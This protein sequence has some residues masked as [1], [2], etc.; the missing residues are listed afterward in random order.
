MK[1]LKLLKNAVTGHAMAPNISKAFL[2]VCSALAAALLAFPPVA[3]TAPK[4]T[5]TDTIGSGG[6][7]AY[8]NSNFNY[9]PSMPG[10]GNTIVIFDPGPEPS[11]N[12]LTFN[13]DEIQGMSVVGGGSQNG[14]SVDNV[15]IITSNAGDATSATNYAKFAVGGVAAG[16]NYTQ[17]VTVTGNDILVDSSA[18]DYVVVEQIIGGLANPYPGQTD[19]YATLVE[20]N[21][22]TFKTGSVMK[23]G[24]VTKLIFGAVVSGNLAYDVFGEASTNTVT[25]EGGSVAQAYSIVGGKVD[26]ATSSATNARMLVHDNKVVIEGDDDIGTVAVGGS[27]YGG[28]AGTGTGSDEDEEDEDDRYY[29]IH[30]YDNEVSISRGTVTNSVVG[31]HGLEV[32]NGIFKNNTV[33]ISG[34]AQVTGWVSGGR[35]AIGSSNNTVEANKSYIKGGSVGGNAYGGRVITGTALSNF[36]AVTGGT[37]GGDA[38]GGYVEQGDGEVTTNYVTVNTADAASSI[39]G[40]YGARSSDGVATGNHAD[41]TV[42]NNHALTLTGNV[43]GAWVAGAGGAAASGNYVDINIGQGTFAATTGNGLVVGALID[44]NGNSTDNRVSIAFTNAAGIMN[45]DGNVTGADVGGNGAISYNQGVKAVN[46]NVGSGTLNLGNTF[47]SGNIIGAQLGGDGNITGSAVLISVGSGS[48]SYAEDLFGASLVGS[49]N[50]ASN[51]VDIEINNNGTFNG[52]GDMSAANVYTDGT[53]SS[54]TVNVRL[55]TGATVDLGTAVTGAKVIGTGNATSNKVTISCLSSAACA[56]A[57]ADTV[58]GGTAATGT[59]SLNEVHLLGAA[60]VSGEVTG[61]HSGNGAA[62]NN[63]VWLSGNTAVTGGVN[64]AYGWTSATGNHVYVNDLVGGVDGEIRGGYS[65]ASSGDAS[66]N[67]V[68]ISDSKIKNSVYGGSVYYPSLGT[69]QN[70]TVTLSGTIDL[71]GISSSAKLAGGNV[72]TTG[73]DGFTGNKLVL[74]NVTP[75]SSIDRFD[76]V[77]NFQTYDIKIDSA[78]ARAATS[79]AAPLLL[80]NNATFGDGASGKSDIAIVIEGADRLSVGETLYMASNSINS[81]GIG[82]VTVTQ[83]LTVYTVSPSAAGFTIDWLST[84]DEARALSELPLADVSFVNRGSD[85]IASQAIPAAIESVAGQVG[86]VAFAAVG[87]GWHRTETGSHIDVK[88]VSAD[89]GVAVG[90]ETSFGAFAAGAFFEFGD[91]TFE[92]FN[93]IGGIVGFHGEGDVSYW[94]GG[95]FARLDFGQKDASRPYFEASFRAG[96]TNAEFR[97]RDF[98][99]ASGAEI[100]Y[101]MDAKYW[102]FHAGGGY[103]I[104]FSSI[105]ATLD[106]SA[107]YFHT[108]RDGDDV[109]VD[110]DRTNLSA[111]TSSRIIAGGRLTGQLTRSLK[112]YVGLYYEHEF[113]GDSVVTYVGSP[114]PKAS[115]GGSTGIGELGLIVS[116]PDSPVEVQ[117][118][119][120]GSAGRRDSF[121]G[122]LSINYTF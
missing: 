9:M 21:T 44:A 116:T 3:F 32:N 88:G 71:S 122:S 58:I 92:S 37:I 14:E 62:L 13:S 16:A 104:E 25:F 33:E 109:L 67:F 48:L 56:Q 64:G 83:H 95:V 75:T 5:D 47:G 36:V 117:M 102:G 99:F 82:T 73:A 26:G 11:G 106:L 65:R 53:A 38:Y 100:K 89:V 85:L 50:A 45:F 42:A 51:S 121:S 69:T 120:Q 6:W 7:I 61:G 114:L 101:D 35:D 87:Y 79:S 54:N 2:A 57:A 8:P 29:V 81:A 78:R 107:T 66:H 40:A 22:V 17:D 1:N 70:N 74:D 115:L 31:G 84:G 110:G 68:D 55:G 4:Q 91:G 96:K 63:S 20:A 111:V 80:A 46:I 59:A 119:V 118:G 108:H 39:R 72:T 94:G 97:T 98:S 49:G 28:Q 23:D 19:V 103:I 10:L 30:V 27:I 12:E 93:D 112:G 76:T 90:T 41:V 52:T 43:M 18:R 60:T 15:L 86:A 24:V 105:D 77:S 113:D 34:T